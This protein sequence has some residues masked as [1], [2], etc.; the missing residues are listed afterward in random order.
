MRVTVA[1]IVAMTFS[2]CDDSS[3]SYTTPSP[4]K[5]RAVTEIPDP[6]PAGN[7]VDFGDVMAMDP[8]SRF[9]KVYNG[10]T[11]AWTKHKSDYPGTC[12]SY[13]ILRFNLAGTTYALDLSN[14]VFGSQGKVFFSTDNKRVVKMGDA[15]DPSYIDMQMR[16]RAGLAALNGTGV[17]PMVYTP[18]IGAYKPGMNVPCYLR[19]ITM[20]M[21]GRT[22]LFKLAERYSGLS[23]PKNMVL[24]IARGAVR[25][26]K[27]VHD[28]GIL[29]GDIHGGNIVFADK[30]NIE[31]SLSLIDFGRALP[32]RDPVT[33]ARLPESQVRAIR[34]KSF[35]LNEA[36]LSIN[37]LRG[38][39]L[40]PNDDLFR[41]AELLVQLSIGVNDYLVAANYAPLSFKRS[42]NCNSDFRI[43]TEVC[44]MY[45]NTRAAS[46]DDEPK[47]TPFL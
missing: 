43:P 19:T 5:F 34:Y 35:A 18:N 41:L 21:A 3:P 16:D 10:Y 38:T 31:K 17:S 27:T 13:G 1:A 26:L 9:N 23:I 28:A 39:G 24:E 20:D 44:T 46:F 25:L 42:F 4:G 7:P 14:Y 32:F 33:N 45:K 8:L 12:P 30:A 47:Y 15:S 6:G 2:G 29:H 36:L 22:D 11:D 40:T 37:E